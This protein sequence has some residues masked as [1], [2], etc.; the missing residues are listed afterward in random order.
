MTIADMSRADLEALVRR[1]VREEQA[2]QK[3]DE[4]PTATCAFCEGSFPES[5]LN[6]SSG[7]PACSACQ[8][9]HQPKPL[10]RR[11]ATY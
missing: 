6:Y 3:D 5:A 10:R 7:D 4:T 2:A 8:A 1:I 11:Y 9:V